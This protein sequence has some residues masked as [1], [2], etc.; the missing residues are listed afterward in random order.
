MNDQHSL[1]RVRN[2]V[3]PSNTYLVQLGNSARC[4]VI[5]PGLDFQSIEKALEEKKWTPAAILCTHGHFDHVGS[6]QLLKDKYG[7]KIYMHDSDL[8]IA[9]SSNFLL[10]VCKIDMRIMVPQVDVFVTNETAQQVIGGVPVRWYPV[11]GHTPGS[12]FIEV[13]NFLFTGDTLYK[14]AIG[15]NNSPG[16]IKSQLI[17]SILSIWDVIAE[18]RVVYPGHGGSDTFGNIKVKNHPLRE[19][20]GL[21]SLESTSGH[22]VADEE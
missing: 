12:S 10:M 4:F 9:R 8:R 17:Q 5:D 16:E 14:E 21:P 22:E 11:P 1:F 18:E 3:F 13:G 6:A 15:L 2:G 19:M 20:L 7:C